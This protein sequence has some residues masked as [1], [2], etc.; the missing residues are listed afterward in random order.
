M[1]SSTIDHM[2]AVMAFLAATLLFIGLFNQTIQTGVIYQRHK[3]L[4]TKASDLLDTILLNPGIPANWSISDKEPTGFGLQDPEFTEYQLSSYSLMRLNSSVGEPVYYPRTGKTYSNIT[5]G[6]RNFLLVPSSLAL[7]Y[8]YVAMLL[9]INNTYGFQFT[10]T[11]IVSVSIEERQFWNYVSFNISARGLGLPLANAEVSYCFLKVDYSGP[12]SPSYS[13]FF[14]NRMANATGSVTVDINNVL[15]SDSYCFIVYA[16]VG[17]IVGMGYYERT[18]DAE[19]YVVPFVDSFENG[20]V[21]LA[22]SYDVHQVGDPE[23]AVFYTATY[24]LLAEDFTLRE[25]PVITEKDKVV[26]GKGSAQTYKNLT[27]PTHEPGILVVP[28][29]TTGINRYG[30]VLMPWG[31]SAMAFSVTFGDDPSKH[32][33]VATDLRQVT[34]DGIAYQAKLALWS[35]EGYRVVS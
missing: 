26:Y 16:R 34:V 13:I 21:L 35:L 7:N 5:I 17:G 33:W 4:A 8:S 14:G 24:V 15:P 22:H 32:E 23:A 12:R 6:S 25:I 27:I 18:F 11:P 2:V 10:L 29:K 28:Y 31:L 30:I 3:A 20:S 1:V 19:T 9:G